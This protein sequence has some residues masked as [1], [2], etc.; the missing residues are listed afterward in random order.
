MVNMYRQLIGLITEGISA[1]SLYSIGLY[2]GDSVQHLVVHFWVESVLHHACIATSPRG[3]SV[4][5]LVFENLAGLVSLLTNPKTPILSVI[6]GDKQLCSALNDFLEPT[7]SVMTVP[8]FGFEDLSR[9]LLAPSV[10]IF[11]RFDLFTI[12]DY[13]LAKLQSARRQDWVTE[14]PALLEV[15]L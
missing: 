8:T 7:S 10:K 1:A 2:E 13:V 5:N 4:S 6:G 12:L 9:C 14:Q 3:L 15:C 11:G